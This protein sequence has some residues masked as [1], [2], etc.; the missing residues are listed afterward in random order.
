MLDYTGA[1]AISFGYFGGA[2]IDPILLDNVKCSGGET[3]LTA[4]NHKAAGSHNCQHKEDA[5]VI[6]KGEYTQW[7]CACHVCMHGLQLKHSDFTM[8]H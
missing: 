5:G 8:N 7:V 6:C 2:R 3:N 4:C 1:I